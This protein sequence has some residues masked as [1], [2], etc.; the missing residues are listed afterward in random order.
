MKPWLPFALVLPLALSAVA[1]LYQYGGTEGHV[2]VVPAAD[3]GPASD[4]AQADDMQAAER[5]L[6]PGTVTFQVH[7][8]PT[9]SYCDRSITIHG[10]GL[11]QPVGVGECLPSC[12]EQGVCGPMLYTADRVCVSQGFDPG[13]SPYLLVGSSWDGTIYKSMST[14]GGPTACWQPTFV[15]PGRFI[16]HVCATRGKLVSPGDAIPDVC[17]STGVDCVEVI[18]D[19]PGSYTFDVSLPAATDG[20]VDATDG[21]AD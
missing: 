12:G 7:L 18:F 6:S 8:S 4:D 21:G 9:I 11:D 14:C 13:S 3:A 19:F 5:S 15:E 1:C 16:A 2:D 20:S 10:N 17:Q